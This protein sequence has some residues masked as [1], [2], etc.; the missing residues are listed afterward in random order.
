MPDR[1]EVP[2]AMVRRIGAIMAGLPRA[3]AESAWVG[4]RWRVGQAT[5]AHVF[6]GEDQQ[7]AAAGEPDP[8]RPGCCS[9]GGYLCRRGH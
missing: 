1:P 5:V 6:G 8:A 3:E 2:D 7:F 9:R 4:V